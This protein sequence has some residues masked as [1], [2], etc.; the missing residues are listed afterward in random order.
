MWMQA[1]RILL[2]KQEVDFEWIQPKQPCEP[3]ASWRNGSWSSSTEK[4][5][6]LQP[7]KSDASPLLFTIC[8]EGSCSQGFVVSFPFVVLC[9]APPPAFRRL[10][11]VSHD[12]VWKRTTPAENATKSCNFGPQSKR[13]YCT[14]SVKTPYHSTQPLFV[15]VT[16]CF[17]AVLL[18]VASTTA[19]NNF[20]LSVWLPQET[21]QVWHHSQ[22]ELLLLQ[23]IKCS[24]GS[25]AGLE[26]LR[27]SL[28]PKP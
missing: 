16:H 24:S 2:Q 25:S 8:E 12:T 26:A 3:R 15:P 9:A 17:H 18:I 19:K 1:V 27:S 5:Q 23:Q 11:I 7:L 13:V 22:I 10:W 21:V 28:V 20:I 4:Q 14:I 6:F